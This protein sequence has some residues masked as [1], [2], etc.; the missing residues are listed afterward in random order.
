MSEATFVGS[1]RG[2]RFEELRGASLNGDREFLRV[3]N[4][5]LES[6]DLID[7][8]YKVYLALLAKGW[9]TNSV[10]GAGIAN[11]ADAYLNGFYLPCTERVVLAG[12]VDLLN[13]A[14]PDYA[15]LVLLDAGGGCSF[16]VVKRRASKGLAVP[17]GAQ[18]LTI[19]HIFPHADGS[20]RNDRRYDKVG[21][22]DEFLEFTAFDICVNSQGEIKPLIRPWQDR[23]SAKNVGVYRALCEN[24]AFVLNLHADKRH[25]WLVETGERV[26][27]KEIETPLQLGVSVEHVKSLFYAR[28]APMTAAGRKRPIMHWVEAHRR[29][30][31]RGIDVDVRKHLRG[32]DEFDMAGFPF[33]ITNP[34]KKVSA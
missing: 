23:R 20:S 9:I 32:V 5:F 4:N 26:A 29:R 8:V 33:R 30:I 22:K 24:A 7:V 16:N 19:S 14:I 1:T 17:M 25:L 27:G 10:G 2:V 34:S 13:D 18:A 21:T 3:N 12:Q 15:G 28:E 6:E 11:I 31:E